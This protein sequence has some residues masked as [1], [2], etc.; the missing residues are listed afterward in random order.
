MSGDATL[1][2]I[3]AVEINNLSS[4]LCVSSVDVSLICRIGY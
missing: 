3:G 1:H 2:K 4:S